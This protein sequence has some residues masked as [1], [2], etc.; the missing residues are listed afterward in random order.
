MDL[1]Y[2]QTVLDALAE[3]NKEVEDGDGFQ[4]EKWREYFAEMTSPAQ[5]QRMRGKWTRHNDWEDEGYCGYTCSVCD[6]GVDVMYNFC[7]RCGADM[8]G[9][10]D[11][12]D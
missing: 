11:A 12:T 3:I 7:P 10:Q 1:I 5:P 2:R 6:M 9:E 4:Y 8:R